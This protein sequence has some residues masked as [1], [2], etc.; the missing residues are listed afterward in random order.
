VSKII[1]SMKGMESGEGEKVGF[2]QVPCG[3]GRAFRARLKIGLR[4][5]RVKIKTG[6]D[7]R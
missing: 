3:N 1:K 7:I 5:K 6:G 4:G 2:W